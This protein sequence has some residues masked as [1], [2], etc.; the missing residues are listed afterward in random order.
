MEQEKRNVP[1]TDQWFK[2]KIRCK[3]S[4]FGADSQ[5]KIDA[6]MPCGRIGGEKTPCK[7]RGHRN[8]GSKK[9]TSTA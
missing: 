9:N 7:Q 2:M 5:T 6:T 4:E 1:E 8:P 3:K